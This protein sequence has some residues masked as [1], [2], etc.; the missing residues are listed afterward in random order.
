MDSGL[1]FLELKK[2]II[3]KGAYASFFAVPRGRV[4]LPRVSPLAP[5][6]SASA[7]SAIWAKI[8]FYAKSFLSC[9]IISTG[10]G[11]MPCARA[12]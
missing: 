5:E 2:K 3:E 4:E 10:V 1:L 12:R 7:S 9:S 8:F 11:S 6:A